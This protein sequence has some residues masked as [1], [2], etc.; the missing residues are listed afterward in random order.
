MVIGSILSKF[1]NIELST[2]DNKS[3]SLKIG[4][5]NKIALRILG[6]PHIGFRSRSKIIFKLIKNLKT[7]KML[8]A[9]CGYGIYSF[10]LADK[11]Y[12]INAIDLERKRINKIEE[13]KKEYPKI[14]D[15]IIANVGSLTN[16]PFP[17]E[18]FDLVLC[19]EVIEHIKEDQKAF[20]E[21]SRVLKKEGS[22]V[23]TVPT[24][25][26]NNQKEY[27]RFGHV[28]VGYSLDDF[29]NLAIKNN[30]KIEK[31][32]FYEYALGNW[33]FRIHNI[34]KNKIMIAITFYLF[35]TIALLDNLI[36]IGSPNGIIVLLTKEN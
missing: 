10:T 19:S 21:L 3:Y 18:N 9:G 31:V 16:L 2:A 33:A 6:I 4:P 14:K 12:Q 17:K 8:D 36:K 22:L 32:E 29:K 25:S 35:Y 15:N 1:K 27:K 5:L 30:L 26:K 11:G 23:F 13:M 34:L 7:K 24:K 20:S 28:R